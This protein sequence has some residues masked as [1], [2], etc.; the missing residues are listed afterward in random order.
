MTQ[1]ILLGAFG[2]VGFEICQFLLER[3][4]VVYHLSV[5]YPINEEELEDKLMFIGRNDNFKDCELKDLSIE[6]ESKSLRFIIPLLDWDSFHSNHIEGVFQRVKEMLD[7]QENSQ[8]TEMLLIQSKNRHYTSQME[9]LFIQ[10]D[11]QPTKQFFVW[12]DSCMDNRDDANQWIRKKV[13]DFFSIMEEKSEGVFHFQV[14]DNQFIERN[15]PLTN[16]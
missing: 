9:Q 8:T 11:F 5:E 1:N 14:E 3:G 13:N 12:F 15:D 2:E 7:E 10:H 6:E 16:G 4:E